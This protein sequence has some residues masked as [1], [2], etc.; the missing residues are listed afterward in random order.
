MR[1]ERLARAPALCTVIGLT[2]L[3]RRGQRE[4]RERK[5]K[6]REPACKWRDRGQNQN[7]PRNNREQREEQGSEK[8]KGE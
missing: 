1:G 8:E 6:Q 5:E 3:E 2:S 7:V 4:S